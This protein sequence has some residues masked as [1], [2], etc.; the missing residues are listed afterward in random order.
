MYMYIC[1]YI[2]IYLYVTYWL[3]PIVQG[4]LPEW[5]SKDEVLWLAAHSWN[6]GLDSM[7]SYRAGAKNDEVNSSENTRNRNL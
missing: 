1:I 4:L 3:S 6:S 5:L 2:Y 7:A